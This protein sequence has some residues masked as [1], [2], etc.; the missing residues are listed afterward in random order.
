MQS[1]QRIKVGIIGLGDHGTEKL[2]PSLAQVN[3][4]RLI[5]ACDLQTSR[6]KFAKEQYR[7]DNYYQDYKEM[8]DK[9]ELDALVVAVNP[10][11][12]YE[13][14]KYALQR[15]IH[16]FVEKPPTLEHSQLL[17]LTALAE[18]GA[19]RTGVGLNFRYA[20][21][22]QMIRGI[23]HN[24][25][26]DYPIWT[27]VA[28]LSSK[29]R[30]PEWGIES[31]DKSFLLSQTIH[32]LDTLVYFNGRVAD[33]DVIAHKGKFGLT[34]STN[35]NFENKAIGNLLT[36]STSSY[37]RNQLELLTMKGKVF[38][39]D[40]LWNLSYYDMERPIELVDGKR[41]EYAWK[42]SPTDSG[43][44]RSGYMNEFDEFFRCV[45]TKQ[46]FSPAFKDTLHLYEL[47]E[48]IEKY[49]VRLQ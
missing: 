40:W 8:L 37:F 7:M 3:N 36:G 16:V 48:E 46:E 25:P 27:A 47:S 35:I 20:K 38:R 44:L 15:K 2:L 21:P 4:V 12:H 28:H 6:A 32:A 23:L 19:V 41:W 26:S 31:F 24:D 10:I 39:L 49:L 30:S 29:P 43:Y 33:I 1:G 13:V 11:I 14:A 45:E 42:P 22:I 34:I 5:A 17:E 18:Q 9:E